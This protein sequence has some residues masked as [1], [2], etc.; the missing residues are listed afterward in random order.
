MAFTV[1]VQQTSAK[2]NGMT[3]YLQVLT[4]Q[5]SSQPGNT[6]TSQAVINDSFTPNSTSSYVT[7][8]FLG[9]S[10]LPVAES[11]NS[12]F[13]YSHISGLSYI[14]FEATAPSSPVTVG[15]ASGPTALGLAVCEIMSGSGLAI[16]ASTPG[17]MAYAAVETLTSASFTP[18]AGSLLVLMVSSNGASG[19]T[20]MSVS[21]TSG[22]GL[23]WIE[24]VKANG[25]GKGYAGVW[26]AVVLA[27]LFTP[28]YIAFMSSM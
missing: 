24:Q 15:V 9:S 28:V 22:L 6:F 14:E 5:N 23:T 7:G 17:A 18:P 11:A 12:P 2:A 26:T 1:T 8:A 27:P 3:A 4:G 10:T 20:A 13:L 16:D 19:T 25:S 21:D